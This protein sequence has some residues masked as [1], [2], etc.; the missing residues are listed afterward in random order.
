MR[1]GGLGIGGIIVIGLIAWATGI[2][3]ALLMGGAEILFGG[4]GSSQ[5]QQTTAPSPARRAPRPTSSASSPPPCWPRPRMCGRRSSSRWARTYDKPGMV[6]FSAPRARPAPPPSRRWG[7]SIARLDQKS[8][9][10]PLFLQRMG[11]PSTPPATSPRPGI[12]HEWPPCRER[13]ACC[14]GAPSASAGSQGRGRTE[15]SVRVE[16]MADCLAGVCGR[17]RQHAVEDPRGR[18]RAGSAEYRL[19]DRR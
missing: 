14:L 7:R 4:G 15:L 1:R 16:L 18:R 12:A 8:P 17:S 13:G 11:P 10:R 5:T 3:P 9:S 2:N 19:G 6:P